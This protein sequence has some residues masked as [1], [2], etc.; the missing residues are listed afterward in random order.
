MEASPLEEIINRSLGKID[1]LGSTETGVTEQELG[2]VERL[3]G[4][5]IPDGYKD[6]LRRYGSGE[7]YG[8]ELY[9]IYGESAQDVPSGDLIYQY[10]WHSSRNELS[11][12]CLPFL[13]TSQG[14]V[15]Y[16]DCLAGNRETV[17]VKMGD[18]VKEYADNFCD[19][20]DKYTGS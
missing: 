16:F 13:S 9:S 17:F 7:V 20:L 4:F 15:F 14:E 8:D 3:L 18:T 6:F 1:N 11:K 10:R 12:S 19:F 2:R 5:Q